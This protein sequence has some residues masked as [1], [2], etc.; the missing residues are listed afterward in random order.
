MNETL[1]APVPAAGASPT[2]LSERESLIVTFQLGYQQYGL[3][4]AM[5]FEIVRLPALV[6]LAGAPPALC[7]LLNLR[8][9]YLPVLDGRALVGEPSLYDLSSQVVIA[10]RDKPELGLLVDQVHD[11]CTIG[12]SRIAPIGGHDAATFLASVFDREDGSVLLF[13]PAALLVL[14]P[15]KIKPKVKKGEGV[16]K[17]ER[18]SG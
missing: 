1:L 9:Q 17:G 2:I 14:T 11:V 5:V 16:K 13:D 10:G 12:A 6:M 3:P 18:V 4:L 15:S 7:G 8:G